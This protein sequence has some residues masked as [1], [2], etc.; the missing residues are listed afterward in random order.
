MENDW[1]SSRSRR[2]SE[3]FLAGA[4]DL[5]VH[6]GPHL[7]S[8][9][10]STDPVRNALEAKAAGMRGFALMNVFNM[11]VG[12][13]WLVQQVVDGIEVYGGIS[14]NT[15]YGGMNPRAVKT[16]VHYGS[17]ARYVTFG[18]HSTCFHGIHRR[19]LRR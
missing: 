10:R 3:D 5:H 6:A 11:S 19:A 9:P 4:F 16:A 18:T 12:T 8:S 1:L 2:K 14:L 13:A 15:V 17:G 7:L